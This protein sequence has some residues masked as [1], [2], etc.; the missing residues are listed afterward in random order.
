MP[1]TALSGNNHPMNAGVE[2]R[3][4]KLREEIRVHDHAYYVLG[5]PRITDREYD[6]LFDELKNL[7][8]QHPELVTPHSPTQRVGG[9]PIAGFG[10]VTHSVPMLSVDN[11]YDEKQLR[12]FDERVAK[13]LGGEDYRYVVDPKIDGVAVSLLYE[14]GSLTLAATRGDGRTGDDITHNARMIGSIPL[15]LLGSDVPRVLEVRGEIVWPT[16]DF[17]RFN[18]RRE[19]TGEQTFANPRNATAGS[20]KQLDPSSIADRHMQFVAHGFGRIEPSSAPTAS[21]LFSRFASWGIPVSPYRKVVRSIEEIIKRLSDWDAARADYPYETDGLV[22]KV[23]ALDQRDALGSTSRYPRWCI[24][25]KFAAEQAESVL[26]D[27]EF[28][29]GKSGVITPVAKLEPVFLAGTTV[30]SASLHNAVQIERL[31]LRERDTVMIEKAGEIIPQVTRVVVSK[32]RKSARKVRMPETCP[33]CSEKLEYDT[34]EQGMVAFRCENS[35]CPEDRKVLQRKIARRTCIRCGKPVKVVE[36]LPTLRCRNA[37][38][39]AQIKERL[40]HFGSRDA[41]DIEGLGSSA[42]DILVDRGFVKSIPDLYRL[43][44]RKTEL[45]EVP[46][47][48]EKSVA[49]LLKGIED[50][51]T[52]GLARLLAAL[53][54][55]L[56][57]TRI[58]EILA[59]QFCGIQPLLDANE[60]EIRSRVYT[61]G[62]DREKS[63]DGMAESIRRFFDS[64]KG[65]L[66]LRG[67]RETQSLREQ[68]E[69]LQIPGFRAAGVLGARVPLLE[70]TFDDVEA[71]SQATKEEIRDA[72]QQRKQIAASIC[73]FF[74]QEGGEQLVQKLKAADVNMT[75][76]KR[77]R[78]TDSPLA[79]KTVVITGTLESMSRKEAQD[80]VKQAGGQATGSVSKKTDFVVHGASPGSK[81]DKAKQLGVKTMDEEEFLKLLG[82]AK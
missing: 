33:V 43:Q 62:G 21:D 10:H 32:R 5:K 3:V 30:S 47:F 19:A 82:R 22:I 49:Q 64:D 76:P 56:V 29:V 13:G 57:G 17:Q 78:R 58:A 18:G 15:R 74:H 39:P 37:A 52:R 67:L 54:I 46:G 45:A 20:L 14:E 50:S 65:R 11:T 8:A 26:I 4:E 75:Q 27:V 42:A 7:E 12:E 63:E 38:C 77:P 34:P 66:A 73:R 72:L 41:M 35:S 69:Q 16:E 1:I 9:A 40:I 23:D 71:L 25:Y 24:A 59:S 81:L 44:D 68:I 6:A 36:T 2:K 80:L 55:R 31:D 70:R 79:G 28:Q 61:E 60:R 53:N 48:G 51:K